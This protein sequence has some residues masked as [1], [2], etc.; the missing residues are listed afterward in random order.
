MPIDIF[1]SQAHLLD[2]L[3]AMRLV[4]PDVLEKEREL[5]HTKWFAYRFLTPLEATKLF[6][7]LYRAGYKAY[8][9]RNLDVNE[10]EN[11]SGLG[12][13][14]FSQPGRSL[15]ELWKARQRAD[16]LRLP[17]DLLIEFGFA[18][19]ERRTW[20]HAP[21]P[22]QLFGSKDSDIAWPLEIEKWLEDRLPLA[23]QRLD[24]FPQYRIESYRGFP[25]QDEFRAHLL[26]LMSASSSSW[27]SKLERQCLV[28]RHLP[29][30]AAIK[31]VPKGARRNVIRHLRSARELNPPP[32]T[33]LA[34]LPDLD[35]APA[36]FGIPFS[37][38]DTD[39]L[40]AACPLVV[41]CG[42][43]ADHATGLMLKKHGHLSPVATSRDD[44]RRKKTSERVR[45][46]RERLAASKTG[47]GGR[48]QPEVVTM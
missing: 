32:S 38:C 4:M 12:I 42:R 31:I 26:E 33:P 44:N 36:C 46:Y 39:Q 15:T 48:S 28:R 7:R 20:K 21:R 25:A 30:S 23:V 5:A 1:P 27:A 29:I 37:L 34:R 8:V 9:R 2:T 6:A 19:A 35:L 3:S 16:A 13:R 18:F 47:A 43:A 40:C 14:I 11:V 10:A 41:T 17:Y 22:A 24:G 45:R